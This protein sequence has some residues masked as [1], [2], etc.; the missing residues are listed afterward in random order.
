MRVKID[1]RAVNQARLINQSRREYADD[2]AYYLIPH[3][4]GPDMIIVVRN[5]LDLHELAGQVVDA[6]IGYDVAR[7]GFAA[8]ADI[9]NRRPKLTIYKALRGGRAKSF[10]KICKGE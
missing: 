1:R 6:S 3:A 9:G 8:D 2:R 7:P 5:G 10:S 4:G